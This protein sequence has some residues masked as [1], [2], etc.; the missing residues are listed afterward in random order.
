[1]LIVLS[2]TADRMG[3]FGD[4]LDLCAVQMEE[5]AVLCLYRDLYFASGQ[6][7]DVMHKSCFAHK[8]VV[9]Q[10]A[11]DYSDFIPFSHSYS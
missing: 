7:M 3:L 10:L 5:D 6:P 8:T 2:G 1:M 4:H 9:S 11:P